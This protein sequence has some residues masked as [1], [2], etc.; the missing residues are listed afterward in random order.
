MYEVVKL[1][2]RISCDQHQLFSEAVS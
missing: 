1:K 2:I